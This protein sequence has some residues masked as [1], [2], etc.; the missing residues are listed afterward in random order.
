MKRVLITGGNRGIGLE[1]TKLF[2][3]NDYEV[4]VL[5]RKFED[6]PSDIRKRVEEITFDLI[7]VDQI[8]EVCKQIGDIDILI[9]NS[10]VMFKKTYEDY[11]IETKERSIKVNLEAPVELIRNLSPYMKSQKY[12]RIVNLASI[13]GHIGHPDI[14]Y[15][16]TKAGM[17]NFTKAFA[18]FLGEYNI[19]VNSVAPGPVQTDMLVN[20]I[21]KERVKMIIGNTALKRVADPKEIAEVVYW[22]AVEAPMYTTGICI[23]MNNTAY[24]R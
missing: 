7:N 13:A 17:I 5:A 16:I 10:G 21:P 15:G 3:S 11:D 8:P 20:V 9:N 1:I 22:L 18:K 2:L 23:D 6:M 19:T 12:G 4:V 24:L 14:W